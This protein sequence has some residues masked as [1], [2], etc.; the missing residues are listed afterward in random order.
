MEKFHLWFSVSVS[1]TL[2]IMPEDNIVLLSGLF[3]IILCHV[4]VK[5]LDDEVFL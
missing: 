3:L 5:C 4:L 2:C 1:L